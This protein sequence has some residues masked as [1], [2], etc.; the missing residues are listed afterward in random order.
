MGLWGWSRQ[1]SIS[2]S[3]FPGAPEQLWKATHLS[4]APGK[5]VQLAGGES[6]QHGGTFGRMRRWQVW[7]H[8]GPVR[9]L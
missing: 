1:V 3:Q 9:N 2:P 4:H 8:H 5:K 7:A 6:K